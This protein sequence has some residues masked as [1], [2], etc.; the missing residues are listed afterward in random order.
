MDAGAREAA[1]AGRARGHPTDRQAPVLRRCAVTQTHYLVTTIVYYYMLLM[2]FLG[3]RLPCAHCGALLWHHEDTWGAMSCQH[4]KIQLP[5]R[6]TPPVGSH[7]RIILDLWYNPDRKGKV[8]RKFAPQ[9]N[10]AFSLGWH[11]TNEVCFFPLE[12][13]TD[14]FKFL[15]DSLSRQ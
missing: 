7:K 15:Q 10:L 9:F 2:Q 12:P 13:D 8:L 4:G 5:L 3:A 14:S 11:R 1:G 6:L